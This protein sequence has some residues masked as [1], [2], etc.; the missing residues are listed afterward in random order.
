MAKL[1]PTMPIKIAKRNRLICLLAFLCVDVVAPMLIIGFKYKLFTEFN[2]YKLTVMGFFLFV[3]LFFKFRNKIMERVRKWEYSV[4]KY[5][6][7]GINKCLM[8]IILSLLCHLAVRGLDD[9]IYCIDW[10][11]VCSLIA[12][13]GIQPLE[14][15]YD[16]I[17]K[18]ELRKA[19]MREVL[20]ENRE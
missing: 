11:L 17:V 13:C 9:I 7:L 10:V 4:M 19:E 5:I 3:L 16:A 18:R 1:L 20:E 2:G 12:Y 14:E 6:I 15:R 8:F